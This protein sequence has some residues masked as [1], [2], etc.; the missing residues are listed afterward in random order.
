MKETEEPAQPRLADK[1]P[2]AVLKEL[3]AAGIQPGDVQLAV[4]S[5]LAPD[6]KFGEQWLLMDQRDLWVMD[7]RNGSADV[8]Y[9]VPLTKI[10]DAKVERCIGNGLLQVTIEQKPQVLLHYSNELINR[11][12]RVAY[13]LHER[14]QNAALPVPDPESDAHRCMVCGRIMVDHSIKICPSCIQRGKILKRLFG[15]ARPFWGTMA[16]IVV[17]LLT[18]V[19]VDLLPPYLTRILIDDVLKAGGNEGILPWL[20]LGLLGINIVRMCIT[21]GNNWMTIN[22]STRFTSVLRDRLFAHLNTLPVDY[23]DKNQVGRLMTRVNQDTAELQGL[24]SQMTTFALNIMLVIGIGAVLFTMSPSLG[25]YVLIPTPLVIT[26]AYFYYRYMRPHFERF[27]IARWRLNATLNTYLSG[28]RVVK[29]FAQE[30]E[31]AERYHERNQRVLDS[32]LQVDLAWSK[33]YPLISFAFSAGGL[34]IWYAGGRSVLAGAI[35]LGTLMAF[36]SYLGMFYGP[37]SNLT[38]V[39]QTLNQFLTISQRMFEMLDESP[40]KSVE[41]PVSKP[42]LG[43]QIEFDQVSFGYDP[44][45]PVLRDLSFTIEP[46]EMIGVV[47][48]SGAGK[49]TLVNLIG[50]FYDVTQG[51]IRIDGVDIRELSMEEIRKQIGMV[52]Q[53]PFL[54]QGTIAEN[55]SYGKQAATRE[56]IIRAAKAANAHDFITRMPESYDTIV[57]EGGAGLSGGER[58]RISIARAILHDPRVLILDEAT[59]SVDTETERQIQEALEVLVKGRTT[60]AIAHRLSTLYN[61]DR[62][63]VLNHGKLEEQGSPQRLMESKGAFYNL[64]QLQTQLASLNGVVTV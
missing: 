36:L 46:G 1:L 31:E 8:R 57:G 42:T 10:E 34:I 64:V 16:L 38:H 22:L 24:V 18:G 58:Q 62:I 55:I 25:F 3:G 56:E 29:A 39:S 50:R 27:W 41:Q 23:F 11:F 47:G 28:V 35:T 44:Y 2:P 13:Y 26:A 32:R 12:G 53:Q 7:R 33:F 9:R 5:D 51:A 43:G 14:A 6:G 63:I 40:E 60:I 4:R 37:L 21:I 59:S 54:F 19:L 45:F 49:T 61:A 17:F 30:D 15:L 48:P 20:V 52:L